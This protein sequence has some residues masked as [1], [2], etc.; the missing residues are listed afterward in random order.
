MRVFEKI[1][2]W[3]HSKISANHKTTFE[4]TRMKQVTNRG[5]CV[6]AV[7]ASKGARDLSI[8]FK[9]MAKRSD[10]KIVATIE[11]NG[12]RDRVTGRGHSQLLLNHPTDLVIRKSD[13]VCDRTLMIDANKAAA[14]LPRSLI[15]AAQNPSQRII[16]SVMIVV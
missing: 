6:V 14:D 16:F 8:Q 12:Q 2:A 1:E 5:D 9:Q 15:R 7:N 3:G 4:I 10:A 13:Y 11:A